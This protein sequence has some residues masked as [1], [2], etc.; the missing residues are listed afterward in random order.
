MKVTPDTLSDPYHA[1]DA[2]GDT[3]LDALFR[4]TARLH[5]TRMA[6]VDAPDR[7]DWTGGDSRSLTYS[8]MPWCRGH[9]RGE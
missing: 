2:W 7:A 6:L 5:P 9:A 8:L 1:T 4:Q 3:T